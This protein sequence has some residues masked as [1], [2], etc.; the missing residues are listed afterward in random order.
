M[1][2]PTIRPPNRPHPPHCC[3]ILKLLFYLQKRDNHRSRF[4]FAFYGVFNPELWREQIDLQS[5]TIAQDNQLKYAFIKTKEKRASEIKSH[6]NRYDRDAPDAM[7]VKLT[8]IPG[9]ESIISF[10]KGEDPTKHAIY[11]IIMKHSESQSPV[12]WS[13]DQEK[14]DEEFDVVK[15]RRLMTA[16]LTSPFG[17]ET[18]MEALEQFEEFEANVLPAL[19]EID[20]NDKHFRNCELLQMEQD[21]CNGIKPT[22]GGVY[23]AVSDAVEYPKIGATRKSHPSTRLRDLS[24]YVPSPFHAVFWVPSMLPFKTEAAIHRHFD[25]FRI[26]NK[27]ACT[28]FFNVDIATIGEYLQANY[29]IQETDAIGIASNDL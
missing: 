4:V 14:E 12:K 17:N 29:L 10:C 27:G 22:M 5:A 24:R 28:E 23:V 11:K 26:K 3:T 25:S 8:T 6:L 7:K 18:S 16:E 20:N 2:P 19:L 9:Y 13:V 15:K 21:L 1:H